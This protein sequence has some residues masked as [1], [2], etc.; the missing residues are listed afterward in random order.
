MNNQGSRIASLIFV[1]LSLSC[2]T[3]LFAQE[4]GEVYI[5][6]SSQVDWR[7]DTD[8][9]WVALNQD[10]RG[11]KMVSFSIGY[12]PGYVTPTQV[13]TGPDLPGASLMA[14]SVPMVRS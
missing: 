7:G 12:E 3:S 1:V 13:I 9:L 10:C 6:P 8:T 11:L 5:L 14:A 4:I 2:Q